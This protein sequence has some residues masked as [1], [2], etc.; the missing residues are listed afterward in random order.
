MP[1]QVDGISYPTILHPIGYN[2]RHFQQL[3][4]I[5]HLIP[6]PINLAMP[7][8]MKMPIVPPL[9]RM[10]VPLQM[11]Q[12]RIHRLPFCLAFL[13]QSRIILCPT[14]QSAFRLKLTERRSRM[15]HHDIHFQSRITYRIQCRSI[16]S[17]SL[18]RPALHPDP[19]WHAASEH[20]PL[21]AH[22]M[23][24]LRLA[25]NCPHMPQTAP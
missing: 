13:N 10:S 3:H 18:I 14:R 15:T 6:N 16:I 7:R 11:C 17:H 20:P 2:S 12:N 22:N 24:H 19:L 23:P 8:V 9:Q 1:M 4:Y 5:Q 21:H 25:H